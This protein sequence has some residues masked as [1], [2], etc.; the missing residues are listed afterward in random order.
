MHQS[1][2]E[3]SAECHRQVLGAQSRGVVLEIQVYMQRE[4]LDYT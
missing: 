1:A 2:E 4:G 3:L